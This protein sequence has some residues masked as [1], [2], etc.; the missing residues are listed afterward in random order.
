MIGVI[1]SHDAGRLQE[2]ETDELELFPLSGGGKKTLGFL[3]VLVSCVSASHGFL[4]TV[5]H[6]WPRMAC[7]SQLCVPQFATLA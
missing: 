2:T 5:P 3:F 4:F 7:V 1:I 6:A